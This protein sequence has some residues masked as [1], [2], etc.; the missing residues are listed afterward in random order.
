M[1][2]ELPKLYFS[3]PAIKLPQ[4]DG[5]LLVKPGKPQIIQG[6]VLTTQFA[7][8][9]HMSVRNVNLLCHQGQIQ[10]R[11]MSVLPRSR[12]LIPREEIDRYLHLEGEI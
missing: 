6:E 12:I 1:P 10:H 7:K 5:S 3:I 4:P 11:R 8:A 9:T 2:P